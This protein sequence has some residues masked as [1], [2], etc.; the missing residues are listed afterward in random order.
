[1]KYISLTLLRFNQTLFVSLVFTNLVFSSLVFSNV[2]LAHTDLTKVNLVKVD[3]S[4]NKMYL[5]ANQQI[6]KTYHVAFDE[7]PQGH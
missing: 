4:D 3:K 6:I 5:L 7:N 1:M 2:T